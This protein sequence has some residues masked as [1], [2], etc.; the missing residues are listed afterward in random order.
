MTS[1]Y[2]RDYVNAAT[3]LAKKPDRVFASKKERESYIASIQTEMKL[4]AA[5]LDFERAA[6]F[7]DEIKDLRSQDLGVTNS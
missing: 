5:N 1:V 4:A 7:R 2:E 3:H 6:S